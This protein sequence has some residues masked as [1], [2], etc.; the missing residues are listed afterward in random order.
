MATDIRIPF[1]YSDIREK[2]SAYG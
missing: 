2:I 1:Y